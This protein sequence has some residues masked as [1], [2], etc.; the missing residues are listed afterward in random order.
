MDKT[1]RA[2]AALADLH[3]DGPPFKGDFHECCSSFELE[4]GKSS[5]KQQT[6]L[7][8]YVCG[9]VGMIGSTQG[10]HR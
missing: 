1:S 6:S 2:W 7:E 9:S 10:V 4:A 3:M 5:V 8:G